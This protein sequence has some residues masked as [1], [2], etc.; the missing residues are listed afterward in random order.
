MSNNNKTKT[1][2]ASLS[3][4]ALIVLILGGGYVFLQNANKAQELSDAEKAALHAASIEG[5]FETTLNAFLQNVD[6]RV[7]AYKLNRKILQDLIKTDNLRSPE[8]ISENY[9]IAQDMAAQ[10]NTEI[11]S[12][13]GE[14]ETADARIKEL[15]ENEEITQKNKILNRWTEVKNTQAKTYIDFFAFEQELLDRHVRLLEIYNEGRNAIEV[16]ATD[17][18]NDITLLL[19]DPRLQ[20]R[21]DIIQDD[22][23]S[24]KQAQSATL[25]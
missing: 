19:T 23:R 3:I 17:S 1:A 13:L 11:N 12:I 25:K 14:F 21:A 4:I 7:K 20:K 18:N 5:Q 10:M 15:V 6:T 16:I 2:I 24:L 22:I 9:A 8:Y